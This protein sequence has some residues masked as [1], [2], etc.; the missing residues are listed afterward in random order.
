[1]ICFF[2]V[3]DAQFK[4]DTLLAKM[5]EYQTEKRVSEHPSFL[6]ESKFDHRQQFTMGFGVYGNKPLSY[7]A[8][9]NILTYQVRES[10]IADVRLHLFSIA[11]PYSDIWGPSG[12]QTSIDA[13]LRYF[14]LNNDMFDVEARTYHAPG[15]NGQYVYLNFLGMRI[16][17]LY[18]VEHGST[19]DPEIF[20]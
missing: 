16:A 19:F 15:F 4:T 17:R 14:P 8:Y 11:G 2:G 5:A 13:G 7:N 12:L 3:L 18:K 10:L 1:M 20:N 9:T 6:D